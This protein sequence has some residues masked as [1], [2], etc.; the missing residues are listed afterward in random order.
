MTAINDPDTRRLD[1]STEELIMLYN[2][3]Q[4]A[5]S[6]YTNIIWI[7]P[8]AFLTL[9][10]TAWNYLANT[11]D[12]WLLPVIAV[13]DIFFTQ[14]FL[15]LAANQRAIIT[16][17]RFVEGK[18]REHRGDKAV[19]DFQ[20]EYCWATRIESAGLFCVGIAIITAAAVG[21]SIW[22]VVRP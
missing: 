8:G 9:N 6:Y 22:K 20:S 7:F 18:L 13:A 12:Q 4:T 5:I 17:I 3:Y 11:H 1:P 14:A 10:V 16:V 2:V 21:G 19:P 15:K